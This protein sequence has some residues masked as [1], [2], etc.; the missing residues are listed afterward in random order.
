MD[1]IDPRLSSPA[2]LRNR[3]P[4]LEALRRLL[5]A[6]GRALEI[7]SGTGEH[8]LYFARGLP[9]WTWQPSDADADALRSIAGW[10]EHSGLPNLL[11]PVALDVHDDPWPV[12]GPMDLVFC[13]N[14]LHIAPWSACPALMAGA[15]RILGRQGL[16]V[17]YGPYRVEGEPLAPSNEAFDADLRRRNPAWGLRTL[18][19]VCAEAGAAGLVLRQRQ[20]MPANNLLLVFG[21]ADA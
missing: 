14:M 6:N 7:A 11:P 15:G 4:I 8:A 12:S 9:G 13:A 3:Q 17:T 19:A 21:R 1:I 10:V 2:A 20:A 18:Q 5:P 16:L